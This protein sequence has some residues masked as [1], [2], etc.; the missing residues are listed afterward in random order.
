[1]QTKIP[2][3]FQE[4]PIDFESV[5]KSW[6]EAFVRDIEIKYWYWRFENNPYDSQIKAAYIIDEDEVAA[7]YAVS[8]CQIV[9][10][11]NQI[12]KAGLMNMGFT[13]PRFQGK[14][15]YL[16][17]N[18][19]L[20]NQLKQEGYACCFGFA[21]HNSHYP[22]RKHLGWKD[23]SLLTNFE[24]KPGDLERGSYFTFGNKYIIEE[25]NN[26]NISKIAK[27]SVLNESRIVVRRDN[28]FLQWRIVNNPIH[29]YYVLKPN[30]GQSPEVVIVYKIYQNETVD[31]LEIFYNAEANHSQLELYSEIIESLNF[32]QNC[33]KAKLSLWS[34]LYSEEHLQLEKA[35]F[36]EATFSTYFGIQNFTN[37]SD[38]EK[39]SNW[40]FRYIDSDVY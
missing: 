23:L 7:F 28:E 13:H 9:L 27:F 15:Y 1:M 37:N 30:A 32:L 12:V 33:Y 24:R 10:P 6:K 2:L 25:A 18:Q 29:K 4:Y 8:P 11:E 3:L 26:E 34:N 21:N 38:L 20:H 17:V 36:R 40:H 35:G 39:I 22:Y 16:K 19:L 14:G 31:I 5:K